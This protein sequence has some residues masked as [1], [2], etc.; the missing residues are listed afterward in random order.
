[1]GTSPTPRQ[2]RDVMAKIYRHWNALA[3]ALN[4]A[5]RM[6]ILVYGENEFKEESPCYTHY[7][8]DERIE[9]TTKN[10]LARAMEAEIRQSIK[11]RTY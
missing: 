11:K 9:R 3:D 7:R 6:N 2:V 1:M 10:A 4:E 5:H 8:T